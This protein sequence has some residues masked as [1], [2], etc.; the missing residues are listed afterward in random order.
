M[1]TVAILRSMPPA[2][3]LDLGHSPTEIF[4]NCALE[5]VA[6]VAVTPDAARLDALERYEALVDDDDEEAAAIR[7][8]RAM[9]TDPHLADRVLAV[10][11]VGLVAAAEGDVDIERRP[12]PL[13]LVLEHPPECRSCG[14]AVGAVGVGVIDRCLQGWP[15]PVGDM[16]W[17]RNCV[18]DICIQLLVGG[19]N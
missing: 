14:E 19:A 6:R 7:W 12:Y 13:A 18:I 17:C 8:Q 4:G 9:V 10:L 3:F 5:D 11:P 16:V 2:R 1:D 15:E